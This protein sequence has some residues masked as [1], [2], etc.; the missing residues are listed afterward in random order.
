MKC[1]KKATLN[2][3]SSIYQE[4]QSQENIADV[5]RHDHHC[6]NCVVAI[7][8]VTQLVKLSDD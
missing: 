7:K 3:K 1:S 5:S 6:W 2:H 4:K 8:S